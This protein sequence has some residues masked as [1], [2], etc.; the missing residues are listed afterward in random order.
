[1]KT[2]LKTNI[3]T[4]GMEMKGAGQ[5]HHRVSPHTS[6]S[7]QELGGGRGRGQ[8]KQAVLRA[9]ARNERTVGFSGEDASREGK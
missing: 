2:G 3:I 1:M 8:G 5:N 6:A 9:K 4:P 7:E